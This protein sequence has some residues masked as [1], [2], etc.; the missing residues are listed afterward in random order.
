MSSQLKLNSTKGGNSV[1]LSLF[2]Q[3]LDTYCR[4]IAQHTKKCWV[5]DWCEPPFCKR[6]KASMTLKTFKGINVRK[7]E[8]NSDQLRCIVCCHWILNLTMKSSQVKPQS[9]HDIRC[10]ISNVQQIKFTTKY[11]FCTK[12]KIIVFTYIFD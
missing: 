7:K 10:V 2:P 9:N 5:T 6:P 11:L 8:S 12:L 4:T 3:C 1:L